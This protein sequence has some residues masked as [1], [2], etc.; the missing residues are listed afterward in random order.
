MISVTVERFPADRQGADISDA[1]ITSEAVAIER[2]RNEI[3]ASFSSREIVTGSGP[4][5]GFMNPGRL[6]EVMDMETGPWRGRLTAFSL[7]LSRGVAD[8]S[9]EINITVERQV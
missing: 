4:L 8:F 6:V 2:G 5:R 7:S 3:D 9:A 1:L